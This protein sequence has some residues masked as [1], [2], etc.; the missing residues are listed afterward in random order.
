MNKY[1]KY[2]I[3]NGSLSIEFSVYGEE[4]KKNCY[5]EEKIVVT[6]DE[7][8]TKIKYNLYL[9]CRYIIKA[10][11]VKD[12]KETALKTEEYKTTGK[13][14]R[15]HQYFLCELNFED[16]IDGIKISFIDGLAD[17]LIIPVCFIEADKEKY[18]AKKEQ[19]RKDNLFKTANIKT[20]AGADL[21]NIYF[22]PCCEDY[23]RTE[24]VLFKDNMMLAK[25]KIDEE[26]FFKSIG[27]L[28]YGKYTFV[29]KQFDKDSN[30]LLETEHIEFTITSPKP[31]GIM[32]RVNRF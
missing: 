31:Q 12:K 30:P 27:G 13:C 19:E 20:A 29:L 16:K 9:E 2:L 3:E 23:V 18:Y 11:S 25:Y 21:V 15:V 24:I 6:Q 4:K 17:D 8:I 26:S 22:Q 7:D 14:G 5:L 10:V 1:Q 32:P 28:A